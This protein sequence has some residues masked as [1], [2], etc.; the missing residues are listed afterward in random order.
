MRK[1]LLLLLLIKGVTSFPQSSAV[2]DTTIYN[3]FE[4]TIL[5]TQ[6]NQGIS[7]PLYNGIVHTGYA[8]TIVGL[9]YYYSSDWVKGTVY[10]ENAIYQ[11]VPIKYDV[12]ADQLV[13]RRLDGYAINLF[14]PRVSWFIIGDARFIYIDAKSFN[15][16]LTPGFYQQLQEGKVQFLIKRSKKLNEKITNR[17]EQQFL[18]VERFYIIQGGHVREVKSLSSVLIALNDHRKQLKD[19]LRINKLKYRRYPEMVLNK[20]V[21]Y[22]NQLN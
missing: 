15:G 22:Y 2:Q 14:S 10:F 5:F 16:L 4:E 9:P 1:L 11:Q 3:Q 8:K 19:F 18:D 12:V 20:M 7:S 6:Q 17:L 13:V 21:A